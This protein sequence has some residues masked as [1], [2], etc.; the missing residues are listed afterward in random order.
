MRKLIND[1][2]G[3]EVLCSLAHIV[4]ANVHIMASYVQALGYTQSQGGNQVSLTT[5]ITFIPTYTNPT[6]TSTIQQ[7]IG[8]TPTLGLSIGN[9]YGFGSSHVTPQVSSPLINLQHGSQPSTNTTQPYS[10]H[11][12][13]LSTNDLVHSVEK[14]VSLHFHTMFA[15]P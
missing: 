2:Q 11:S 9:P 15:Y 1:D 10:P 3:F 8:I 13:N 12:Q 14:C 7:S 5:T 4:D 6:I